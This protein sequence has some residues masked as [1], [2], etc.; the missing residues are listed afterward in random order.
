MTPN[1]DAALARVSVKLAH[2]TWLALGLVVPAMLAS[3]LGPAAGVGALVVVLAAALLATLAGRCVGT[4]SGA[5]AEP[6]SRSGAPAPA[7]SSR[8]PDPTRHP[9]CPRA[10][11]LA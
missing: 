5:G 6:P 9:L 11:G 8:I 2:A 3:E 1:V 7:L 10:P 4:V